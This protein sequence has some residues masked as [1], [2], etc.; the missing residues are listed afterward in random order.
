M[1]NDLD[2]LGFPPA[3]DLTVKTIHQVQST[4]Y[5]LPSPAFVPDA[6]SPEV[7]LVEWRPGRNG[8]TH[9]TAGSVRVHAEK[10]W[11]EEMM[12]V[13]EGLE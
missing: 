3:A 2:N 1:T 10:E 13:P 4:S 9:E 12:G 11:D 6:M 8:V 5:K 7:L